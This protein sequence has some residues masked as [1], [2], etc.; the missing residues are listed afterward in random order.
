MLTVGVDLAKAPATTA[1]CTVRWLEGAATV[2]VPVVGAEDTVVL[3][4]TAAPG[5]SAVAIDAPFGWPVAMVAA[6]ASWRPGGRWSAPKDAA[7]RL[8]RTDVV[9]AA[10]TKAAVTARRTAKEPGQRP[11]V[12][13]SVSADKIAM[14]AWRCCALLEAFADRGSQIVTG[15]LGAPFQ[16][17]GRP[18][19]VEAYPAAA[20][21]M[22][23]I[24]RE[25]YKGTDDVAVGARRR[26]LAA[27]EGAGAGWLRWEPG[28]R[29]G[30]VG[31]DHALD[32]FICAL[33][34]RATAL[35]LVESVPP[36]D[37]EL[38]A[39]EGW[40]ALPHGDALASLGSGC[41]V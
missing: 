34:A 15:A 23:G 24:P 9:T 41:L 31:T 38:A 33:V 7:F 39:A 32:A 2:D 21:A 6:V 17:D 26:I 1:L 11:V 36:L 40:I 20:L 35:G 22:W 8:R 14:A 30:C 25:G 5:V 12:P 37:Q 19:V 4:A 16:A 3:A 29:E 13:L 28:A 10:W 18:R 27:V